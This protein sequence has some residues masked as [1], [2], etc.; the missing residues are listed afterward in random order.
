MH[1]SLR[2]ITLLEA[3]AV[4]NDGQVVELVM[5]RG[6]RR[7]PVAAFLELAV[8]GQDKRAPGGT[9]DLGRQRATNRHG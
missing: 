2:E 4:D 5:R 8:A 6:Q 7:L 3:I 1:R 9:I